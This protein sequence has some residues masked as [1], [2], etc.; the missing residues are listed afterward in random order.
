MMVAR[1]HEDYAARF[2]NMAPKSGVYTDTQMEENAWTSHGLTSCFLFLSEHADAADWEATAR[3][4][5]FSTCAAPQDTKDLGLVGSETARTLT[6]K[7]L[8]PYP[9][10]S[11]KITAWYTPVTRLRASLP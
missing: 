7:S 9:I 11:R 4:W 6:A 10:I 3:R 5:M 8:L 1:V 2:G